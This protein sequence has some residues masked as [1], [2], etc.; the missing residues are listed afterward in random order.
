MEMRRRRWMF[1]VRTVLICATPWNLQ[2]GLTLKI[3]DRTNE[4][5]CLALAKLCALKFGRKR[6]SP[7]SL[8]MKHILSR[9]TDIGLLLV[10]TLSPGSFIAHGFTVSTD[11]HD[12]GTHRK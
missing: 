9:H 1:G 10:R 8:F 2:T 7:H 5:V 4:A 3:L 12:Y 6:L 11:F